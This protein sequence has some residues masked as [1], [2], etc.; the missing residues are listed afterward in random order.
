[1]SVTGMLP[2]S[3]TGEAG[4]PTTES[5]IRPVFESARS[6]ES[7]IAGVH[8]FVFEVE[9]LEI[10]YFQ[11]TGESGGAQPIRV[12]LFGGFDAGWTDSVEALAD[13]FLQLSKD[14]APARNYMLFGYPVVNLRGFGP[15][16]SPLWNFET[17]YGSDKNDGDVQFF[18]GE[19]KTRAFDGLVSLRTDPKAES[20]H[21]STRGS[22]LAR[23]VV[24]PA[25]RAAGEIVP[26]KDHP[27]K[28]RPS[29]RFARRTDQLMG[30]LGP[31]LDAQPSP[32]EIE[33]FAPGKLPLE[34]RRRA[35]EAAVLE[36]L[37]S[38][39]LLISHAPNL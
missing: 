15:D 14:P 19:L 23:D 4:R 8:P 17:R 34:K 1:M 20:F 24:Q 29:D 22:V 2:E 25:L 39:R 37:S 5:V 7:L 36:I 38:Y 12:A 31:L 21:A 32:F 13:L 10:P 3:L 26:L 6:S 18:K 27:L 28:L 11:L 33:L 16:P 35:L 9:T 30:R